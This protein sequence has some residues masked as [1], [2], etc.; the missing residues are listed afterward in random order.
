MRPWNRGSG[1]GRMSDTSAPSRWPLPFPSC[2]AFPLLLLLAVI[3]QLLQVQEFRVRV[4]LPRHRELES[5]LG[6]K[7]V[8]DILGCGIDVDLHP[9]HVAVELVVA[10]AVVGRDRLTLVASNLSGLVH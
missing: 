9:L 6:A 1:S 7:H 4:L 8:I 5:F 3:L 2:G 10:R